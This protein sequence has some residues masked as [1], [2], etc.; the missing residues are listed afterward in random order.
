MI[1]RRR[2]PPP[3]GFSQ[4]FILKTVKVLC[5]HALLQ[6]FIL[7]GLSWRGFTGLVNALG[8]FVRGAGKMPA[9]PENRSDFWQ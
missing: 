1:T 6:V 2:P 9:L 8:R 5:F 7:K 3:G 4:V